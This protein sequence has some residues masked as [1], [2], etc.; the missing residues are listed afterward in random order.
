MSTLTMEHD[1]DDEPLSRVVE[2]N[3]DTGRYRGTT[4]CG[5]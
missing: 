2:L 3:N 4:V 5:E 1:D